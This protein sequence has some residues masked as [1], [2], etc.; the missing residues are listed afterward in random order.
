MDRGGWGY[1]SKSSVCVCALQFKYR[2]TTTASQSELSE[3]E[4]KARREIVS[5]SVVFRSTA[6]LKS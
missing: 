3:K 1:S 6:P 5:S 4:L 2:G